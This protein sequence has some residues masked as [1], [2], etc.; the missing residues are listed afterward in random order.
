MTHTTKIETK[1]V[2]YHKGPLVKD[3][4]VPRIEIRQNQ[5]EVLTYMAL[6]KFVR[7]YQPVAIKSHKMSMFITNFTDW[8]TYIWKHYNLYIEIPFE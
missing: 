8:N 4:Q 6:N 1:K 3:S 7:G 5:N 2:N